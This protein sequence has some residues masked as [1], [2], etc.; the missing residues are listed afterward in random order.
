V[1][2]Y[3]R[4]TVLVDEGR[5]TDAI[6]LDLSKAFNIVPHDTLVSNWGDMDSVDGPLCG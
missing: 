6:Y 3:N 4:V 5:A 2:F 1:A